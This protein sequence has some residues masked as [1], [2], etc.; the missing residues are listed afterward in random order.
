MYSEQR[1][2]RKRF[3]EKEDKK[4]L[5][6]LKEQKVK[7][8]K[9]VA[10]QLKGKTA[11]QVRDR[12]NGYLKCP[13]NNGPFT[14][15]EDSIILQFVSE[16]GRRWKELAQL[17][18]KRSSNQVKN[19]H[20]MLK[21]RTNMKRMINLQKKKKTKKLDANLKT[22]EKKLPSENKLIASET[23]ELGPDSSQIIDD[24]LKNAN[25]E[26]TNPLFAFF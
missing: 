11:K 2:C 9:E 20:Q 3:T 13:R 22:D 4:I 1:Y 15:E 24:I 26:F 17:L 21:R 8:W 10:S 7:K 14:E 12:Y 16:N 25:F 5:S 6:I 18:D 23:L 19:R